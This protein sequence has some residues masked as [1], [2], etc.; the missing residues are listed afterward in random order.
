MQNKPTM[1]NPLRIEVG[2]LNKNPYHLFRNPKIN[3]RKIDRVLFLVSSLHLFK[4]NVFQEI[5]EPY[6]P[7]LPEITYTPWTIWKA[8]SRCP[9][10]HCVGFEDS[11]DEL[12]SPWKLHPCLCN[13]PGHPSAS[14]SFW[15]PLFGLCAI[16][17]LP[18]R[19][20]V[21]ILAPVV[22]I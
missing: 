14:A 18:Y 5:F 11:K 2:K 13:S 16:R 21:I 6:S 17:S 9:R 4:W 7:L 1:L 8:P 22:T 12:W 20:A 3:H 10:P 19:N 15:R